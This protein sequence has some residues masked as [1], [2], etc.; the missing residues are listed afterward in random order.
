MFENLFA[1]GG[2]SLER[3][4]VLLDVYDAGSIAQAASNDPVR[5]S[6]YSRQLRELSEF[7]GCEVIERKGKT[8]KLTEQGVQVAEIARGFLRDLSDFHSSCRD[9][10][11]TFTLGAGDS[12]IH[13][14]I[15]PQLG[16]VSQRVPSIRLATSNLRTQ[17]IIRQVIDSRL[18]FGLVRKNAVTA[19]LKSLPLGSL[20]FVGVI[21]ST[22]SPTTPT[23]KEFFT[24]IPLALQT[25][26]GE[27][28][29]QL[30][31][32]AESAG[33]KLDPALSC[34]SFPQV[35]AATRSQ[36][37]AAVLPELAVQTLPHGFRVMRPP[38]FR[39]LRR[40]VSLVWN[41]RV[42]SVRPRATAVMNQLQT[43]LRFSTTE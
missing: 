27:F 42:V 4:K 11:V 20:N 32:I 16:K 8:V 13:W 33:A 26:E 23:L 38:A 36:A 30:K 6:Q 39:E 14:L 25:T 35:F 41:P 19:G 28:T 22:L 1:E 3:L 2:L 34:Q 31:G 29:R 10:K 43:V 5:Q 37:F 17:E 9:D 18:D 40:D 21:P 12:L 15:I 7:F 24:K